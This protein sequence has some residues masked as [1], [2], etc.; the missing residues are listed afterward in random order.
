MKNDEATLEEEI[1]HL[2]LAEETLA[3]KMTRYYT[4]CEYEAL[5]SITAK[6]TD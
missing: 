5:W 3:V 1:A 2:S 4:A 6:N